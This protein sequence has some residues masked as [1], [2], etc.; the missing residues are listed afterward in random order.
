MSLC[1]VC[2]LRNSDNFA[3]QRSYVILLRGRRVEPRNL[4]RRLGPSA[5]VVKDVVG[6]SA[7]HNAVMYS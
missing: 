3:G 2:G 7:R 5:M 6:P 4:R 1:Q